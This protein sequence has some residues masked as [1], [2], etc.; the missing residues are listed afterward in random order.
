VPD[1]I[2]KCPN[3]PPGV[4]VDAVGCP[5]DS[6]GDGVPDYLDKCPNTP[7]GTKVDA[8]GCPILFEIV[9]GK[10]RALILKG[11]NFESGRSILTPKSYLVLDEVAGSLIAHPEVRIEIGGHTDWTGIRVKNLSLS[12]AR[13]MTVRAYLANKG[14]SPGR[15][16]AK[17]YGPDRPVATNKTPAGRA[18]NRRVELKPL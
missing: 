12:Q 7:R 14:I 16:V 18:Q 10:A 6:D 15:M 9:E 1:D 4:K 13:A 8:V 2:D 17:G 11:V 5:I 3:T